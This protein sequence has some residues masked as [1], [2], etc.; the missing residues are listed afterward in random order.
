MKTTEEVKFL[1]MSYGPWAVGKL[2]SGKTCFVI[3]GVP[4]ETCDVEVY[5]EKKNLC[6]GRLTESKPLLP[7]QP[8]SHLP[9]SVQLEQKSQIIVDAL[10]RVGGLERE[11]LAKMMPEMKIMPDFTHAKKMPDLN[12]QSAK[13]MPDIINNPARSLNYRNKIELSFKEGKLGMINEASGEFFEID[14]YNLANKRIED[15]PK[16]ISGALRFA[17]HGQDVGI[18]RVGIRASEI[19]NS[20]EVAIW[21]TP[22]WFPRAEVA[23]II[24]S[25]LDCTSL[26]R[27][28]A[29]PGKSRKIK[30][31]EV[32]SGDGHWREMAGNIAFK[33][34]APSF[35]QVNSWG[36][37]QLQRIVL[38]YAKMMPDLNS[39]DAKMMPEM[40]LS[41]ADFYCGCGTFTLPLAKCGCDVT[42][43]ELA[44][45]S[46]KDLA[47]NLKNNHLKANVICDDVLKIMPEMNI[48][49]LA[50]VDPPKSGL[51][52]RVVDQLCNKT[53]S[54]IYVS[55]DPQTLARDIKRF[56]EHGFDLRAINAVDMFPQTYHV[57]TVVLLTKKRK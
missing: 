21:T 33:V 41:V 10:V 36:A 38:S 2:H 50:V 42:G 16:K 52:R 55:C 24:T 7:G 5:R 14:S 26:V 27:V 48:V 30:Q 40:N 19:T 51:E 1:R 56:S 53:N 3:G 49:D 4:G 35:F 28:I 12:S 15:A 31:V 18:F 43:V 32:L 34:S 39:H 45:S 23:R 9:Y 25:T 44:G 20:L 29:D 46:S 11:T 17:T 37:E 54:V 8:W 22:G 13:I 57:E 47:R 6:F